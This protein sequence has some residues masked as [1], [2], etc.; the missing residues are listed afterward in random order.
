MLSII[1]FFNSF[2]FLFKFTFIL[3]SFDDFVNYIISKCII[4]KYLY[5]KVY[6]IIIT[7]QKNNTTSTHKKLVDNSKSTLIIILFII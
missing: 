4:I 2:N 5:I 1:I 6:I 3:S 7:F